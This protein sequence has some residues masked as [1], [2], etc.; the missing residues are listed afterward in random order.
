MLKQYI[1]YLKNNPEGYWFKRS[2]FGWGWVPVKWQG[3]LV[4]AISVALVAAGIYISEIDDAPGAALLGIV[5]AAFVTFG[6]GYKKGEK[7]C[8]QWGKPDKESRD[9]PQ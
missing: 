9:Q 8:W 4:S 2:P 7:A 6:F 3:W 5:L 1:Q